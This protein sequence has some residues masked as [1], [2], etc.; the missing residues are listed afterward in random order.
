MGK[1]AQNKTKAVTARS[2]KSPPITSKPKA[3]AKRKA[4]ADPGKQTKLMFGSADTTQH[5]KDA[6]GSNTIA[7]TSASSS[8]RSSAAA[9]GTSSKQTDVI[10]P[11]ESALVLSTVGSDKDNQQ[12]PQSTSSQ[13]N[14]CSRLQRLEHELLK[15]LPKQQDLTKDVIDESDQLWGVFY[16]PD[17]ALVYIFVVNIFFCFNFCML[18]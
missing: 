11:Q 15:C 10:S 9:D 16:D 4:K 12:Q 3:K 17:G 5:A 18:V 6:M 14:A 7:S 8:N 2:P 13:H 1:Q